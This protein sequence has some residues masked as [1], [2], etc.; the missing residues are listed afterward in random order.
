MLGNPAPRPPTDDEIRDVLSPWRPQKLRRIALKHL[1]MNESGRSWVFLRTYYGGGEADDLKLREWLDLD[2][3]SGGPGIRPEDEWWVVLDDAELF[4]FDDD[5]QR[6]YNVFPELAAPHVDRA[7]TDEEAEDVRDL[8]RDMGEE[9]EDE[10][11]EEEILWNAARR[12][13]WLV[14]MDREAFEAPEEGLGFILC[15]RKG[16]VVKDS[17]IAVDGFDTWRLYIDVKGARELTPEWGG[18]AVG[19]KYKTRGEIML[20][21]MARVKAIWDE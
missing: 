7:L 20:E 11:I 12:S 10:V 18:G 6:A 8:V 13:S 4:G 5:W 1:Q 19:R 9:V 15:D 16:N 14:V 2:K 17:L 21:L 3:Y